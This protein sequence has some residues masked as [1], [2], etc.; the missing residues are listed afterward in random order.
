[1]IGQEALAGIDHMSGI[2]HN[3]RDHC[4]YLINARTQK[5]QS[6]NCWRSRAAAARDASAEAAEGKK[7]KCIFENFAHHSVE[8]IARKFA[9]IGV[10]HD[11][12]PPRTDTRQPEFGF[13]RAS[14][15]SG[16]PA[17]A[18]STGGRYPKALQ[19]TI[20]KKQL[21]ISSLRCITQLKEVTAGFLDKRR[22]GDFSFGP[23]LPGRSVRFVPDEELWH[24]K[25]LSD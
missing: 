9:Y 25:V 5:F 4:L 23:Y 15:K 16:R 13:Y 22:R 2:P 10:C 18:R 20:I 14:V 7:R 12:E 1:V 19:R 3:R 24:K 17:P 11:L 21:G 6:R 8:I